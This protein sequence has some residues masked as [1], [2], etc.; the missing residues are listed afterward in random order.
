MDKQNASTSAFSPRIKYVNKEEF[1][2]CAI[3]VVANRDY[4]VRESFVLAIKRI[5]PSAGAEQD[6][7]DMEVENV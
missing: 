4:S 6:S 2:Q 3:I 1:N 7:Q 5:M